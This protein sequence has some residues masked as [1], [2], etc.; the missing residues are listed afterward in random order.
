MKVVGEDGDGSQLSRFDA[1]TRR[2]AINSAL[3]PESRAFLLAHRLVR[4]EFENEM[5]EVV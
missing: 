1:K 3:P 4:Y 2:L 5:R